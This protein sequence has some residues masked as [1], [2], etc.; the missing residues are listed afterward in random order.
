MPHKDGFE[1]LQWMRTHSLCHSI[2]VIM[3]TSSEDPADIRRAE[4]LGVKKFLGKDGTYRKMVA[5]VEEIMEADQTPSMRLALHDGLNPALKEIAL[6]AE[7]L[8]ETVVLADPQ[9]RVE[10][11]SS[12]FSRR[13]GFTPEELHGQ[14]LGA[15]LQNGQSHPEPVHRVL[16]AVESAS[17]CE[18]EMVNHRKDGTACP[19]FVSLGPV[20]EAGEIKGFLALERDLTSKAT[21][22]DT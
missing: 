8:G 5:A 17:A 13:C 11:V 10:W 12:E 14:K 18:C 21:R 2:P 22:D 1:V 16:H 7:H 4:S 6:M 3:L 19:V 9:G 20:V 15:L